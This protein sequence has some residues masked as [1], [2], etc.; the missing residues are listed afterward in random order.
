[1]TFILIKHRVNNYD[2]WKP[3][4]D[5][6]QEMASEKGQLS[7]RSFQELND[8]NLVTVLTEFDSKEH[9]EQFINSTELMEAMQKAGVTGKPEIHFLNEN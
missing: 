7:S 2:N 3:I 5:E 6:S 8:P 1:M 9:G 4:Y